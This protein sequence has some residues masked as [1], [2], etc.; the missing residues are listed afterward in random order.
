MKKIVL[1]ICLMLI[2]TTLLSCA[3]VNE[4]KNGISNSVTQNSNNSSD[5]V[6]S[7]DSIIDPTNTTSKTDSDHA[8][9]DEI[10]DKMID[11]LY[12]LVDR[13][14]ICMT[15]LFDCGLLDYDENTC[16]ENG[17]FRSYI[18]VDKDF[19]TLGDIEAFLKETYVQS[20]VYRLMNEY[21]GS[22]PRYYEDSGKLRINI[23]GPSNPGLPWD[24]RKIENV[25]LNG[26]VCEFNVISKFIDPYDGKQFDTL[27]KFE[28]TLE[29]GEWKLTHIVSDVNR[30]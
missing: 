23:S 15:K 10:S 4:K 9:T 6:I 22:D 8:P 18:V 3:K 7:N 19:T 26:D 17:D 1:L 16:I 20:E 11:I 30:F 29:N 14:Y 2:V 24:E 13:D 28:A 21:Y 5:S 12:N 25:V 27:Y